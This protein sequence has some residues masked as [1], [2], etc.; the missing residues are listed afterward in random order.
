MLD[1]Y[2]TIKDIAAR[3]HT[4]DVVGLVEAV[5]NVAPEVE[6]ITGR[7]IA[8]TSYL[9]RIR[10]AIHA[11]R[12]FRKVN[13]G[14]LLGASTYDQTRFNCFP[15]DAQMQIDE[16]TLDAAEGEGDSRGKLMTEEAVGA[17]RAKAIDLGLQFYQGTLND[18]LGCPGLADFLVTAQQQ[19]DPR[20]NAAVDL[21]VDA[22]GGNNTSTSTNES[23][24][25]VREGAQGVHWL[26]GAGQGLRMNPWYPQ[27]VA[28][29]QG[30]VFRAWCTNVFGFIGI[31]SASYY[32]VGVI[33]NVDATT[34][35]T[36]SA[37]ATYPLNDSLVA[38]LW[39]KF[40]IDQ[41]PT[42]CFASQRAIYT[43]QRS[44]TT[45][46]FANAGTP[47]NQNSGGAAPVAPWPTSLPT[48][49]GIPIIPTDSIQV[50]KAPTAY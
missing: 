21:V 11:G 35:A 37:N 9:A 4:D 24:W 50:G 47:G 28:D 27:R 14:T 17:M 12:A 20:T 40:P 43:L 44:R 10:K 30:K 19:I 49:G 45:T 1:Q 18:S 5:V 29:A 22:N 3:E 6:Q 31:S 48:A 41:K 42:K 33:K 7:V 26:F 34:G 25:F 32:S 16:A 38:A 8:G 39:A 36:A 23:V 46:L 2:L 13:S 15:F